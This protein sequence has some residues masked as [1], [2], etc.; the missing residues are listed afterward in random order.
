MEI[1]LFDVI[2]LKILKFLSLRTTK[3]M[4]G[5]KMM[6]LQSSHTFIY[7]VKDMRHDLFVLR[8]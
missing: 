6:V 8:F 5:W 2:L 1:R 3:I 4:F 7:K